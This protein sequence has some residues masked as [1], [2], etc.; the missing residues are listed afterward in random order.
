MSEGQVSQRKRLR[1]YLTGALVLLCTLFVAP[2]I[3]EFF[4]HVAEDKGWYE[5]A[6]ERWDRIVS[7]L[8]SIV[9]SVPFLMGL[10][11]LG[12]LVAGMWLDSAM[13]K[14][15]RKGTSAQPTPDKEKAEIINS[16][17]AEAY[18]TIGMAL[19]AEQQLQ[20]D[21]AV[22]GV[23]AFLV[24][25]SRR[26]GWPIPK[27]RSD[28]TEAGTLR[29]LCYLNALAP[30]LQLDDKA[31]AEKRANEIVPQ[32]NSKSATELRAELGL[33]RIFD[34]PSAIPAPEPI[35]RVTT[36]SSNINSDKPHYEYPKAVLQVEHLKITSS[37]APDGRLQ[38]VEGRIFV[39]SHCYMLLKECEIRAISLAR[40]GLEETLNASLF[41]RRDGPGR[42]TGK[43]SIRPDRAE[44]FPLV[45]RDL[46]DV[47]SKPPFLLRFA[48]KKRPLEDNASYILTLD[49]CSEAEDVTRARVEIQTRAGADFSLTL[50]DQDVMPRRQ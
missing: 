41:T 36:T 46:K 27:L 12:G 15:E 39:K 40:E 13:L 34:Q 44:S 32:L 20:Y 9:S 4:I 31:E 47:V 29:A 30:A 26:N 33:P 21:M 48:G 37:A 23:E 43:F 50:L 28:G 22:S 1:N 45:T 35:K 24:D 7:G 49:L 17:L 6:G 19:G 38:S 2:V 16:H 14:R 3:A 25:L 5:D 10:A 42:E 8:S 18:Q 11:L